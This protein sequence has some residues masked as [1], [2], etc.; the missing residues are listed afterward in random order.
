MERWLFI[1]EFDLFFEPQVEEAIY[2]ETSFDKKNNRFVETHYGKIKKFIE[3]CG[4]QFVY[5]P[6]QLE[7]LFENQDLDIIKHFYPSKSI[8]TF[9]LIKIR[10]NVQFMTISEKFCYVLT[11]I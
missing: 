8:K 9:L 5:L 2:I 11:I 1:H 3:D 7:I 4:F 6:K 10:L